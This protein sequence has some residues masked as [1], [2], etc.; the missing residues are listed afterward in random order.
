V[1]N[2]NAPV[3]VRVDAAAGPGLSTENETITPQS[4]LK[5]AD[6]SIS[7]KVQEFGFSR[8]ANVPSAG[9]LSGPLSRDGPL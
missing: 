5:L 3:C 9:A 8:H 2:R 6:W 7:E 4:A 1:D